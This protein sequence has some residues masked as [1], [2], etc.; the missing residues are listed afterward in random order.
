MAVATAVHLTTRNFL[1]AFF[2]AAGGAA[3][4]GGPS[5]F[6]ARIMPM[7]GSIV[8]PP[9]VATRIKACIA[10]CHSGASCSAFGS[11]VM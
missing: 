3:G 4:S 10:A 8:G 2:R 5:A 7:R 6:R 1:P 11:F 9:F